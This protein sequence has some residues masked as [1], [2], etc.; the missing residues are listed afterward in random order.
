VKGDVV[1]DGLVGPALAGE[2]RVKRLDRLLRAHQRSRTD[3]LG[4]E[5]TTEHSVV[6]EVLIT[7]GEV[8]SRPRGA[9]VQAR[10]QVGPKLGHPLSVSE[11]LPP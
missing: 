10:E 9:D 2:D 4:E 11:I 8:V 1:F 7:G 6:F 3:E 5:L